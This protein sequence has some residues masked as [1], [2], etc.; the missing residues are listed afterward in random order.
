[1]SCSVG[2]A[3]WRPAPRPAAQTLLRLLGMA[4]IALLAAR[5]AA[6][7]SA[8]DTDNAIRTAQRYCPGGT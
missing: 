1:M 6:D 8:G 3:P 2:T 7:S 4:A 5:A